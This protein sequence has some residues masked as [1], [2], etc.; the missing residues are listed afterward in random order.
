V[1]VELFNEDCMSVMARYPDNHFDLACVDPPYGIGAAKMVM[2]YSGFNNHEKKDWDNAPPT[3]EYFNELMRV[4]RNQ[5]IWGGN[6]FSLPATRCF[7]VWDKG[8]GF[9]GRS[10][11]E[12]ELAWTS[13]CKNALIFKRDPLARGDYKGRI[14]PTE[15]PVKLYDWLIGEFVKHGQS[16]LDT[17]L[18]SGSSAIAAHYFGC[19]FVGCEIDKDYYKAAV[20]RFN[21]ETKQQAMF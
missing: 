7:L 13:F 11:A 4:S 5:I 16:I 21:N 14:H 9:K 8:E 6:Y 2:G 20:E 1:T 19:D 10:Y 17:H 15:K 18:G 3:T 12:C